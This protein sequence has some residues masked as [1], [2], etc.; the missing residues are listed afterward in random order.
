MKPEPHCQ[1]YDEVLR[2]VNVTNL[3]ASNLTAKAVEWAA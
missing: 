1:G 2:F 3:D